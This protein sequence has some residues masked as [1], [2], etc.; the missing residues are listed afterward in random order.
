M[1]GDDA[2]AAQL[3]LFGWQGWQIRVPA[4]WNPIGLEGD[5]ARGRVILADL[6]RARLELAWRRVR[7]IGSVDLARA[8]GPQQQ[9]VPKWQPW[10]VEPVTAGFDDARWG[11]T[12][13]GGA[14]GMAVSRASSRLVF[15]RILPGGPRPDNGKP[16]EM[17]LSLA[18]AAADEV[19]PW[20]VYGF[21]WRVPRRFRL[22]G[23]AFGAG[24]ARVQFHAGRERLEFERRLLADAPG[25]PGE[26]RKCPDEAAAPQVELMHGGHAVAVRPL[27][28][29]KLW[30]RITGGSGLEA[31]WECPASGRR[32]TVQARG[33]AP[34]TLLTD[35]VRGLLCHGED[36][37]EETTKQ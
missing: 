23:Q 4:S 37:R 3:Q 18:D 5:H 20:S 29:G 8:R 13:H 25:R 2:S 16:V 30:E 22:I 17:L 7:R 19:I 36:L 12:E 14:V 1:I 11:L 26:G 27:R 35:A 32:Y 21:A 28:G 31:T 33:T 10:P 6:E 15:V 34:H 24:S 9:R